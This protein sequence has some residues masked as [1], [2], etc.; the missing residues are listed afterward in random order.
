MSNIVGILH[1]AN[2]AYPS[3]APE[4]IPAFFWWSVLVIFLVICCC[5]PIMCFTFSIPCCDVCYDVCLSPVFC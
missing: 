5:C 4:F 3:R 1:E 2:T